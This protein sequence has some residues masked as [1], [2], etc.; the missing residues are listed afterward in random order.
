MNQ[1]VYIIFACVLAASALY[2]FL[3]LPETKNRTF[4]DIA[5][6]L[7]RRKNASSVQ[8][9]TIEMQP[10]RILLTNHLGVNPGNWDE[11]QSD[12]SFVYW[13]IF[14]LISSRIL[15]FLL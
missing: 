15:W 13:I 1:F 14:M 8:E 12:D 6:L 11:E 9:T 3:R 4:E 5:D 7:A 10:L 2:I